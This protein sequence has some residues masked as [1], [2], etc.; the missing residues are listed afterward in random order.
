VYTFIVTSQFICTPAEI[1][2]GQVFWMR[3]AAPPGS[4]VLARLRQAVVTAG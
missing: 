4:T 3:S 1:A 2:H